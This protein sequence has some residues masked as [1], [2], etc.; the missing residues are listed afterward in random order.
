MNVVA[1]LSVLRKH[2]QKQQQEPELS[3]KSVYNLN[4]IK[5]NCTFHST[6][7]DGVVENIT[8]GHIK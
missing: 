1:F 2:M 5:S 3:L 7:L 4:R 8:V 6:L